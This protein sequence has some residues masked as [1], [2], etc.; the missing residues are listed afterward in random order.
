[1]VIIMTMVLVISKILQNN[2]TVLIGISSLVKFADC[3]QLSCKI[4]SPSSRW[5]AAD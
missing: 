1:M 4:G 5:D 2:R 3:K